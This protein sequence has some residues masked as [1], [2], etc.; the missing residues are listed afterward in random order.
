[1]FFRVAAPLIVFAAAV[2][3]LFVVGETAYPPL[4]KLLIALG[5]AFVGSYLPEPS[6]FRT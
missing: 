4:I 6:S 5:A 2:F 3:Y 1:M